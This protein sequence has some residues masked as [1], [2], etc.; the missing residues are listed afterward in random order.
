MQV[1]LRSGSRFLVA[2]ALGL[3]GVFGCTDAKSTERKVEKTAP[4][5]VT[6]D[7]EKTDKPAV[8]K[9]AEK[10]ETLAERNKLSPED[11][12]LVDA[13]EWCVI[14]DEGRLGDMGAPVK[15][16][17]KGETVFVCCKSCKKEAEAH[18]DKT[19]AK[20]KELK[21]KKAALDKKS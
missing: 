5:V 17:I 20:L 3:C 10:D 8:E 7:S 2:S 15:L 19:L 13:Q 21:A 1:L 12:K 6:T 18:P 11:R 9:P 14:S 16:T 4:S